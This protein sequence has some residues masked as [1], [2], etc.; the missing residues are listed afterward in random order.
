M[1]P[2]CCDAPLSAGQEVFHA[3]DAEQ[4][5]GTVA[6]AAAAPTGGWDAIV[7][8]QVAAAEGAR[9]TTGPGAAAGLTLLPLPYLLMTDV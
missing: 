5:C 1:P 6:Q 9:L 8:M 4:P 7:S 2:V 3:G